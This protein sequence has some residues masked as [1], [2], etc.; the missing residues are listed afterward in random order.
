M[1][2]CLSLLY[3]PTTFFITTHSPPH[4]IIIKLDM[5]LIVVLECFPK[6]MT[7]FLISINTYFAWIEKMEK[8]KWERS[9]YN[10][11]V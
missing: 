2:S 8:A 6:Y 1:T 7:T 3:E 4:Q 9:G 10:I 11:L 5:K